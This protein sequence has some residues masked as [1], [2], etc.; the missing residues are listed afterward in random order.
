M[1]VFAEA[2]HNPRAEVIGSETVHTTLH[3][4]VERGITIEQADAIATE[5]KAAIHKLTNYGYCIIHMDPEGS[6]LPHTLHDPQTGELT[7]EVVS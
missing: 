4:E 2:L 3:I 7:D 1:A 5:T 6:Q